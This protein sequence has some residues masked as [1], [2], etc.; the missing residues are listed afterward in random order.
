MILRFILNQLLA[1]VVGKVFR[2]FIDGLAGRYDY[3]N[4]NMKNTKDE[5]NEI[6]SELHSA[7]QTFKYAINVYKS[8]PKDH[9][10]RKALAQAIRDARDDF[11]K[12]DVLLE[13]MQLDIHYEEIKEKENEKKY[14]N[15][16]Y[17]SFG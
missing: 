9:P 3:G 11:T 2:Y 8:L 10:E 6:F 13:D 14:I 4:R 1:S 7:P 5:L 16:G 17:G 12:L 15:P